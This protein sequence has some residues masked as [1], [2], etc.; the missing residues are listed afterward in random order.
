MKRIY[1]LYLIVTLGLISGCKKDF[2]EKYPLTAVSPEVFFKTGTDFK[3][4]VNQFYGELEN[5]SKWWAGL[6]AKDK[7][8]DNLIDV[9]PDTKLNGMEIN[10]P[11]N[12]GNWSYSRSEERRVGKECRSRWSPYP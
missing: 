8:T 9:D 4:Y 2:L 5:F 1:I 3:L 6:Y 12:D 7:G 10:V 11:V